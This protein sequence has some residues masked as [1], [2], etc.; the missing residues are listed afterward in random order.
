MHRMRVE[1]DAK[2]VGPRLNAKNETSG[3]ERNGKSGGVKGECWS[4]SCEA[5]WKRKAEALFFVLLGLAHRRRAHKFAYARG[6]I[7]VARCL[8]LKKKEK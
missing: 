5:R 8:P 6:Q 1:E 4:K 7:A 2:L 3:K